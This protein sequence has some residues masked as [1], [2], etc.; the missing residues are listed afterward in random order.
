M[1]GRRER[2]LPVVFRNIKT[3]TK[4]DHMPYLFCKSSIPYG[5]EFGIPL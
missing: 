4:A 5:M 1:S 2:F 3:V